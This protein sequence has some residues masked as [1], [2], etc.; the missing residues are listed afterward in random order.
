MSPF[1]LLALSQ[2]MAFAQPPVA[3]PTPSV[4]PPATQQP[5]PSEPLTIDQ[6]ADLAERNAFAVRVA[7]TR[8]ER[9]RQEVAAARGQLGPQVNLGATYTRFDQGVST[10]FGPGSP[11]VTVQ[12]IDSTVVTAN[13]GLPIDIAGTIRASVRAAE[14][15][16][17]AQRE[18]FAAERNSIR[19]EARRT[20]LQVLRTRALVGVQEQS[21]RDAEEQLRI[22]RLRFEAG[23]VARIDVVRAETQLQQAQA[24]L[25]AARQGAQ[26]SEQ[27]FNNVLA[28]PI[29]TPVVLQDVT[30]L[31]PVTATP[32][33]LSAYAQQ[34][35]PEVRAL[36]NT[37]DALA[38][39][40]RATEAGLSPSLSVGV[41][42]Q[43]NV[44]DV[45][46]N[47]RRESTVG[48]IQLNLPVFDSGVTRARVRAARQDEEQVRIQ[49]EQVQL[50][51]SL[52]VRQAYTNVVNTQARLETA[53]K[54]LELAQ[55]NYRVALV[56]N[57]AGEGILLELT[58]AQTQLT[59]AR[60]AVVSARYD[61]LQAFSELQRA[62][63]RD[64]VNAVPAP[65]RPQEGNS[66]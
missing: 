5:T 65:T 16:L 4:A 35:R 31:P 45:G 23:T 18:T 47:S 64:D 29:D 30:E 9:S 58:D 33:D 50:G 7:A 27:V 56:R 21:V 11:P 25:I 53:R 57:Q 66:K 49:L 63:G 34:N 62:I 37:Q 60:T 20:F 46:F 26:L 48:T 8:V 61:Y 22:Q 43:R 15:S 32:Q 55:E 2:A 44:G 3:P 40:R 24:D 42:Y 51:V 13:V 17:R 14:A 38:N 10:S 52:E 6:A 28:R 59:A 1:V 39:V 36:R 54:Q 41:N 12:P 19:L